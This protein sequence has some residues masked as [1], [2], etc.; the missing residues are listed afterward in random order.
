MAGVLDQI[1]SRQAV[2]GERDCYVD[3][4]DALRSVPGN[5]WRAAIRD[6]GDATAVACAGC[7]ARIINRCFGL[8][9]ASVKLLPEILAFF[10]EHQRDPSIDLD[11]FGDYGEP[12]FTMLSGHGLMQSGFHQV[13][14][15]QPAHRELT[16]SVAELTSVAIKAVGPES[17][18]DYAAI[19]ERVF[20]PGLLISVLL[21]HPNFHCF[22]ASVDGQPAALGVLH[23]RGAVASMANGITLPEY[24]GRGLQ[25]SLLRRRMDLA[26]ELGC[27]LM[28]SQAEPASTSTRNQVRAGLFLAGT[29][30]IWS[31]LPVAVD[32]RAI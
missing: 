7:S 23:V 30:S 18:A 16:E 21:S 24:R 11:P 31:K 32:R 13:L 20:G 6:F 12:F 29:K 3:W 4:I 2:A 27:S 25:L 15:G 19:H 8:N 28:V 26:R 1:I 17:E 9:S 10:A 14:I 22:L 5:P